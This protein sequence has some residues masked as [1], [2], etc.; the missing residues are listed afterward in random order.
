MDDPINLF[1]FWTN[2]CFFVV[3]CYT[4]Q[5]HVS[6]M[7]VL[8]TLLTLPYNYFTTVTD[9]QNMY[10]TYSLCLLASWFFC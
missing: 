1:L 8:V 3:F 6:D 10:V 2:A 9:I 4:K 5:L 7:P